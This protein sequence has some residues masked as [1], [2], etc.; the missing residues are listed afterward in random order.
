MHCDSFTLKWFMY[1]YVRDLQ[2]S[3]VGSSSLPAHSKYKCQWGLFASPFKWEM[4]REGPNGA[5]SSHSLT[6]IQILL[7]LENC[8]ILNFEHKKAL[9]SSLITLCLL[10]KEEY[11]LAS[12]N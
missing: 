5:F 3:N 7:P 9:Q 12:S 1:G 4:F 8:C 2:P 6:N 11:S 10:G